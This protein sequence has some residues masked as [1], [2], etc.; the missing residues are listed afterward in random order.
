MY[1]YEKV[2]L[3]SG[4]KL[5]EMEHHRS[6]DRFYQKKIDN[7]RHFNVYY[8]DKFKD[9]GVLDYDYEFELYIEHENYV[10]TR[11]IYGITYSYTIEE[12]EEILL[13]ERK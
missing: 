7:E 4:Y 11:Y 1:D 5:F 3:N 13:G 9:N 12:I 10:E 8:Y 2:L 6:C